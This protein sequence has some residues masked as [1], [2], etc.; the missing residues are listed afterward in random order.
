[1]KK[2]LLLPLYL[3]TFLSLISL[4]ACKVYVYPLSDTAVE[5]KRLEHEAF[6]NQVKVLNR[7]L[8]EQTP[9]CNFDLML[10]MIAKSQTSFKT[11][12]VSREGGEEILKFLTHGYQKMSGTKISFENADQMEQ[13]LHKFI[14]QIFTQAATQQKIIDTG[15]FTKIRDTVCPWYPFC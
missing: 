3:F 9:L 11:I 14:T 13:H 10:E 12:H 7:Q 8:M 4:S 2:I 15:F 6:N 1:M 5:I